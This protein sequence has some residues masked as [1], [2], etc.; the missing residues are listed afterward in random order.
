ADAPVASLLAER[1]Q[2]HLVAVGEKG[3]RLAG[4]LRQRLGA[5]PRTLEQATTRLLRTPGH[6]A[7]ADEVAGSQVA[8]VARVVREQLP[9]RPIHVGDV[10]ATHEHRFLTTAPHAF[11]GEPY[12]DVDIEAGAGLVG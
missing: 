7:A 10:A 11:R 3:A 6:G 9:K 1:A 12:L 8:P 2:R 4:G 5:A